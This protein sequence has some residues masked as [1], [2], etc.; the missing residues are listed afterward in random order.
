MALALIALTSC[1]LAS[2][3]APAPPSASSAP[4][5]GDPTPEPVAPQPDPTTAEPEVP[6]EPAEPDRV[7]LRNG[8]LIEGR[9]IELVPKSHMTIEVRG[10]G[11]ART[12]NWAEVEYVQ[13][14]G[15]PREPVSAGKPTIAELATQSE[16]I[17]RK[18][19]LGLGLAYGGYSMVGVSAIS[20]LGYGWSRNTPWLIAA[21][22]TTSISVGLL[23]SGAVI[24][25]RARAERKELRKVILSA[26]PL[27]RGGALGVA[28]RF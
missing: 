25:F 17:E 19:K 11:K 21:G 27:P 8:G 10:T 6:A 5:V 14:G 12:L 9:L 20:W 15:G 1:L 3:P 28:A 16:R 7:E 22:V 18:V 13:R 4:P 2:Y 23:T 24:F 26:T